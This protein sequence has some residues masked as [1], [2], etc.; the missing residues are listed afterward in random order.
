MVGLA[1]TD[2]AI[3]PLMLTLRR[4]S[5]WPALSSLPGPAPT[6]ISTRRIFGCA[7]ALTAAKSLARMATLVPWARSDAGRVDR[8][9]SHVR[10]VMLLVQIA[11][12]F[13]GKNRRWGGRDR[14]PRTQRRY[15]WSM[16]RGLRDTSTNGDVGI[17]P[18]LYRAVAWMASLRNTGRRLDF[19]GSA[20]PALTRPANGNEVA[21]ADVRISF[22]GLEPWTR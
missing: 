11:F 22:K 3:T 4:A 16:V 13:L 21:P 12:G 19:A 1:R 6:G 7:M 14:S 20:Y 17:R 2:A 10:T 15:G 9:P 5:L 8:R 18:T